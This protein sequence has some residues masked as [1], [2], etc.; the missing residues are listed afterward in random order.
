[1]IST[2]ISSELT[3]IYQPLNTDNLSG[4]KV[5]NN[6]IMHVIIWQNWSLLDLSLSIVSMVKNINVLRF[7]DQVRVIIV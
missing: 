3:L 6:M 4:C 7:T 1:M 5:S 2:I